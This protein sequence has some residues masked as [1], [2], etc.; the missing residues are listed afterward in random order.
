MK[1]NVHPMSAGMHFFCLFQLNYNFDSPL[2]ESEERTFICL[3]LTASVAVHS[4]LQDSVKTIPSQ[5]VKD[6]E[7]YRANGDFI[8]AE[9]TAKLFYQYQ[10]SDYQ[11]GIAGIRLATVYVFLGR[12]DDA[13]QLFSQIEKL[14]LIEQEKNYLL[15]YAYLGEAMI[16]E[17]KRS[18]YQAIEYTEKAI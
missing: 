6:F 13:I 15:P 14:T 2:R 17:K 11:K 7:E 5:L 18:Y 12:Y 9:R 3:F 1:G 8:N 4:E 10:L 16:F